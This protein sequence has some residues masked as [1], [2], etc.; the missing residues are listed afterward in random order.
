MRRKIA[1]SRIKDSTSTEW[2]LD[3]ADVIRRRNQYGLNDIAGIK[4]NVWYE[5]I[6]NTMTD[7]MIWFLL[8]TS[9]L[10]ACL[11]NNR[12]AII[13]ALAIIPLIG[14]DAFLHWRT[15]SSTQ[16]LIGNLATSARVVRSGKEIRIPAIE[17]VPGDLVLIQA[18]EPIPA[19]GLILAADK[20]QIEESSLTG[21]SIPVTKSS[22]LSLQLTYKERPVESRYWG[23]AGTKILTGHG[24]LRVVFTGKETLYGQ[25]VHS[26]LA[27][28]KEKTPLQAALR[29][30]VFN[31]ILVAGF[32]CVLLAAV[33]IVQGF[34]LVDAI[35]SAATLAVAAL[36]DEFPIVLTCY[37][38]VG[39]YRLAR[40][41]ALVRRA[42]SVENLGRITVICS[43]KT[44]TITEG[45]FKIAQLFPAASTDAKTLLYLAAIASREDSY[46]LLDLAIMDEVD[47]AQ[48]NLE[49]RLRTYPFTEDRKRETSVIAKDSKWLIVTKG[50][51]ETIMTLSTLNPQ[52]KSEWMDKVKEL[53]ALRFKVIACAKIEMAED[54]DLSEPKQ[55]YEWMGLLA[56]SDPVRPGVVEA[57]AECQGSHIHVLM[58]TGDHPAT[59][60]AIARQIGLGAGNP[61]VIL[62]E[63]LNEYIGERANKNL[64]DIDVIARAIPIQKLDVVKALQSQGELVAVTGDGVNDVPA[65]KAGNIGIAMGERGSQSAREVS[66]IVLLDD[67]FDSIV[68]AISEGRQLFKNIRCAFNY[69]VMVHF[70]FILSAALI[71]L[72]GYPLPFYPI[73][74]VFLELI[75]HPTALLLFQDIPED[76]E[77]G[78]IERNK[79]YNFFSPRDWQKIIF[80]GFVTTIIITMT[81]ILSLKMGYTD[82][83]ARALILAM[84]SSISIA[85]TIALNGLSIRGKR[86]IIY[87][88]ALCTVLFIQLPTTAVI[89]DL[90]PLNLLSWL[91]VLMTGLIT[92]IMVRVS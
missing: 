14:M 26:A 41:K 35:L 78:P 8:I 18:G 77:L 42:V 84:L 36:P 66:D 60:Q 5:L 11:G 56:F 25:I 37:L 62:A 70:P 92:W 53:A 21:E 75:I 22:G 67:N 54:T 82:N 39:V 15:Q 28:A 38:G 68:N 57:I 55:Y 19:D 69:L 20:V 49:P 24:L 90:V 7:P 65:L 91:M 81:F 23:F 32:L 87:I 12:E 50:A 48:L 89:L 29:K 73:H 76:N 63:E 27:T 83:Y 16:S 64:L 10:F 30:L 33:R 58:I 61:K 9:I 71:P 85:I 2:S 4:V 13:L 80:T 1:W 46:D 6:I 43:D 72:M 17:L 88:I 52:E 74:I 79:N 44:G 59:A 31:L 40:K 47:N 34:G 86:I 45:H 51:P 3:N